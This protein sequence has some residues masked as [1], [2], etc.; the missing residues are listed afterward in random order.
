VRSLASL[1]S[2]ARLGQV[3]AT[4]F[5]GGSKISPRGLV[6]KKS[7]KKNRSSMPDILFI[8]STAD[9][10]EIIQYIDRHANLGDNIVIGGLVLGLTALSTQALS[11]PNDRS[12]DR[13]YFGLMDA[14]LANPESPCRTPEAAAWFI[15]QQGV[16]QGSAEDEWKSQRIAKNYRA[17]RM[18]KKPRCK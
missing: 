10:R 8:P 3:E 6:K 2:Q 16:V 15:V 7:Q 13:K 11:Q 1:C 17:E 9:Q 5:G 14:L 4:P 12:R 18:I